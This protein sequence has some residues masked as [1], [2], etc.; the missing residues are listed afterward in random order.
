MQDDENTMIYRPLDMHNNKIFG[1]WS[2]AANMGQTLN[3]E[4]KDKYLIQYQAENKARTEL[5]SLPPCFD[6][7]VSDVE[8]GSGLNSF[9]KNC[10]RECTLK[11]ISCKDDFRMYTTQKLARMNLRGQR[12]HFV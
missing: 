8:T 3:T 10:I 11:R 1:T 5:G 9:E 4:N 2:R 6:R 12:D 7:C